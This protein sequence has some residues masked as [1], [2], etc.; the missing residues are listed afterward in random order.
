M[1]NV[2]EYIEREMLIRE[3]N[4]VCAHFESGDIRYAIAIAKGLALEQ[5]A[6]DVVGVVRCKNCEYQN[7]WTKNGLGE[8]FCR[9]S[10][11]WNL[12]DNHFC[13]YGIRKED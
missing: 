12:T 2:K 7:E 4:K 11:L 3:L 5:P 9:R 1:E 6:V 10:G 13:S 8:Y